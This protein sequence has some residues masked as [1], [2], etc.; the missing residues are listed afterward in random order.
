MNSVY[1]ACNSMNLWLS[2]FDKALIITI[3]NIKNRKKNKI[4][5][6]WLKLCPSPFKVCWCCMSNRI[7][8]LMLFFFYWFDFTFWKRT[9]PMT[10]FSGTIRVWY[11]LW[12]VTIV[13][14]VCRRQTIRLLSLTYSYFQK[15]S[16]QMQITD[17]N[18]HEN[19]NHKKIILSNIITDLALCTTILWSI[20]KFSSRHNS[21]N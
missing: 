6:F 19:K 3:L 8:I 9:S 4:R 14:A 18:D 7:K 12:H 16:W 17:V 10:V 1:F 21:R 2:K 20:S 13:K 5:N 11:V 15:K